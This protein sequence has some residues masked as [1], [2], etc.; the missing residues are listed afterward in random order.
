[1][2][3]HRDIQGNESKLL[4]RDIL[5]DPEAYI[6]SIERYSCSVVSVLGWGRRID[7][8]ND[9]VAKTALAVMEGVDFIIPGAFL[10]ESIPEVVKL[11]AWLYKLPAKTF[12]ESKHFQRYFYA[13][14]K[15]AAHMPQDNFAK[16]LLREQEKQGLSNVDVANLT[17]NLIG[18]GVDTTS[19]TMIT[20]ILAMCVFQEVQIKAQT[21]LDAV[22]GPDRSPNWSDEKSLPYVS[23][24]VEETLRWRTVTVLG[25]IPHAPIKNDVYNGYHIPAGTPITENAWAIHRHP[26]E[27]PEPDSFR[28]ERFLNGLERPYP[29]IKGHNAFG[30]G[31][32]QCSGQPL[33]QQGLLMS[34]A[35]LLWAFNVRPGLDEFVKSLINQ[36]DPI[37]LRTFANQSN[38]AEK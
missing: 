33:A 27:F 24:L 28:P 10:M 15:E 22:V 14:S 17:S 13:L 5:Q 3:N 20:C 26:R 1:V 35:R 30:W 23:A 31:R 4:N 7:K 2:R 32:R 34:V 8:I 19:S 37:V 38:R 29:N 25:G 36:P 18:G 6:M 16:R 21:E 11:P 9:Y 12:A